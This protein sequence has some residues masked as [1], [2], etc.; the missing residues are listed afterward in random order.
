MIAESQQRLLPVPTLIQSSF[1][2]NH[3]QWK[4]SV[5]ILPEALSK[6]IKKNI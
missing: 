1:T 2:K 6:S 3:H 5:G 4:K